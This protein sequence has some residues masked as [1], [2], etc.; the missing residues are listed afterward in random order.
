MFYYVES[1]LAREDLEINA[2]LA[3]QVI[4][5]YCDIYMLSG[6]HELINDPA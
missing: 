3:K 4:D 1:L 6:N 5:L 2:D